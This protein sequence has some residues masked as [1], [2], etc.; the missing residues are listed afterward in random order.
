[1]RTYKTSDI[2]K[3]IGVHP[4]TVRL[5]EKNELIP[6]AERK[7]NGYRIYTD[8][9]LEQ[10]R[11]ARTAF[12]VEVLQNGLR[13]KAVTIIKLSAKRKFDQAI[14]LAE[15]YLHQIRSEQF[16]A[17]E[18][19]TFVNEMLS[20]THTAEMDKLR[21][22]RK[23][24]ADYLKVSIDTLRNWELNGL[25]TVKRKQ[26]GYRI[27][28]E[29][30][31]KQLKIIRSLRC[32]NYSLA[33]ILRMLNALSLNCETNLQLVLDTPQNEEYIVSVCDKLISSL[34]NAE[35]NACNIITQLKELKKK[36]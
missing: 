2:A 29:E 14:G 30:D 36:Y 26:N 9:H 16:N 12:E 5:Y 7:E 25:L 4:N 27:Y 6:Q 1:M 17:K 18:A 33:A 21:L 10:F 11:L 15:D 13:K 28:T 19:I 3:Q 24:V 35:R 20:D 22:N 31:V 32:A 34:N 23:E 8:F